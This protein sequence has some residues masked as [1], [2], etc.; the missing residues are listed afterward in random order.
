MTAPWLSIVVP[1]LNEAQHIASTLA[2]LAPLR[3][4]GVE[5]VLELDDPPPAVLG[6]LVAIEQ[7]LLNLLT[8]AR[9]ARVSLLEYLQ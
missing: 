3:Q 4:R 6:E 7:V 5:V 2:S 1:V 8:N 9:D